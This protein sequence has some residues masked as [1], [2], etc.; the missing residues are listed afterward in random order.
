MDI[1]QAVILGLV[2]G[3]TE[4]IPVSSSAHLVLVPWLLKW[5]NP[6]LAFD[7]VLHLGTLLAVLSVFWHNF[8]ALAVA[9]LDHVTEIFRSLLR[10]LGRHTGQSEGSRLSFFEMPRCAQHDTG[11]GFAVYEADVAQARLAWW[12]L[13]G[14]IPAA[15]MG[16]LWE[17]QFEALFH[18]PVHVSALLLVTGLW[19]MLAERFG[20]KLRQVEDL[21]W[22]QVLFI[23]AAQGCAIA[24]GI[25]R[26]GATIGAGLLLGLQREAATRFSFLLATP[27]IFGAGLL[28]VKRLLAS[29]NLDAALLPLVLG[30]LGAFLS[31]YACIR[32]LL[33]FV[34]RRGL[35]IFAV[36]CFLVGLA[37]LVIYRFG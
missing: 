14:T 20:R 29:P 28:Q 24:P 3:A 9:W 10:E 35:Q 16:V 27:I 37:T 36:Y 13:L 1:F 2:Q 15:L 7:T 19:L 34:K 18:S 32:F 6:G 33:G 30:F 11:R 12:I 8:S 26:S 31:G 4:F 21:R 22:W 17:E 23:G 25:S 5:P